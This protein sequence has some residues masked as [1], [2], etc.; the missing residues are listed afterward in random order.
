MRTPKDDNVRTSFDADADADEQDNA[1]DA[2]YLSSEDAKRFLNSDQAIAVPVF[3]ADG[4]ARIFDD[5]SDTRRPIE[6]ALTDWCVD[7]L[8]D[9]TYFDPTNKK[10]ELTVITLAKVRSHFLDPTGAETSVSDASSAGPSSAPQ[11]STTGTFGLNPWNFPDIVNPQ[12]AQSIPPFLR[13]A[14]CNLLHDLM[15]FILLIE[16]D[17]ICYPGC[18]TI[19]DHTTTTGPCE[20]HQISLME[21]NLLHMMYTYWRGTLMISDP[22]TVSVAHFDKWSL[23][24]FISIYEGEVGLAWLTYPSTEEQMACCNDQKRIPERALLKVMRKG[25]AVYMPPGTVHTVVRLPGEGGAQTMGVAGHVLRRGAN[26]DQ[27][28]EMMGREMQNVVDNPYKFDSQAIVVPPL[29]KGVEKFL[30]RL[31]SEKDR[32]KLGGEEVIERARKAIEVL[33]GLFPALA[34]LQGRKEAE[35]AAAQK[36]ADAAEEKKQAAAEKKEAKSKTKNVATAGAESGAEDQI[37]TTAGETMAGS[38]R[39]EPAVGDP[40]E[41]TAAE[42]PVVDDSATEQPE[43]QRPTVDQPQQQESTSKETGEEEEATSGA[44][45]T[46]PGDV[47]Y[48]AQ[49]PPPAVEPTQAATVPSG[50]LELLGQGPSTP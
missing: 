37:E 50:W 21:M 22:G 47:A 8:E 29:V 9:Q 31:G 44:L 39:N 38:S 35:A 13:S 34:K 2:Y 40:A 27:W 1:P 19:A 42:E 7:P 26:L 46:A 36:K 28:L 23:G 24:T 4:A 33:V 12:A 48:A 18:P 32:E 49:P 10:H 43:T 5:P 41:E 11:P 6:Q 30:D 20:K 16:G 3:V 45:S 25:D 17:D 14:Q 15:R